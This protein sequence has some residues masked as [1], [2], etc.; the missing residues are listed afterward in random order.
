M[1]FGRNYLQSPIPYAVN[2]IY[3]Y[4]SVRAGGRRGSCIMLIIRPYITGKVP[5]M[6]RP[7]NIP[8]FNFANLSPGRL[9]GPNFGLVGW[10]V[11]FVLFR[12]PSAI[13]P[14]RERG[15]H[16]FFTGKGFLIC[17]PMRARRRGWN[18]REERLL[19][20]R[21]LVIFY[22]NKLRKLDKLNIPGS[23]RAT[24]GPFHV[25]SWRCFDSRTIFRPQGWTWRDHEA[26]LLFF[27]DI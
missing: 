15:L 25:F 26:F 27:L 12:P 10:F 20:M 17:D 1:Q 3:L 19:V 5:I 23:K 24:S 6:P 11:P 14:S 7:Y 2:Y 16:A 8:W 4:I 13:R 9:N 18:S 21:S 22:Y